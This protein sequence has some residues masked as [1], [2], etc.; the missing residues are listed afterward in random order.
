MEVTLA[1]YSITGS[2]FRLQTEGED[3]S[4]EG[5]DIGWSAIHKPSGIGYSI[6]SIYR[7]MMCFIISSGPSAIRYSLASRYIRSSGSIFE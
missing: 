5:I 4:V 7:A 2:I 1:P 6:S 3:P